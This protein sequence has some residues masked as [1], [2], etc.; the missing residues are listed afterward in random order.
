MDHDPAR[1][2]VQ[3]VF[4]N[5]WV[6]SGRVRRC[7]KSH[8]SGRI[9]SDRVGPGQEVLKSR[10]SDRVRIARVVVGS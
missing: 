1:G 8:G 7:S 4:E 9:G 6:E 10:G 2:S 3:E 5:S